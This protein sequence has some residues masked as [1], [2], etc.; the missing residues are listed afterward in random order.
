MNLKLEDVYK[1][2]KELETTIKQFRESKFKTLSELLG[3]DRSFKAAFT[4]EFA[5]DL[6]TYLKKFEGWTDEEK[7]LDTYIRNKKFLVGVEYVVYNA[8][9]SR[10]KIPETAIICSRTEIDKATWAVLKFGPIGS[11]KVYLAE[12]S[13][14]GNIEKISFEN[15]VLYSYR[16]AYTNLKNF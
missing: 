5:E 3:Y 10:R 16:V 1:A 2:Y 13:T 6:L 15:F 4:I 14:E 8:S 9:G 7:F 12:I 11:E